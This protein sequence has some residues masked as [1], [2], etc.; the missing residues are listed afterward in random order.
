MAVARP[1][2]ATRSAP[3]RKESQTSERIL[4]IVA[5]RTCAQAEQTAQPL[6]QIALPVARRSVGRALDLFGLAHQAAPA[7]GME[8]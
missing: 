1:K 2:K 4:D 3:G 6:E 5:H 8:S 7:N